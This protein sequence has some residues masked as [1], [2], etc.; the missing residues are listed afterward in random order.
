MP[1][2]GLLSFEMFAGDGIRSLGCCVD[3]KLRM[4]LTSL[5]CVEQ[6][7]YI[8]EITRSDMLHDDMYYKYTYHKKG[9]K[10]A[11]VLH[12]KDQVSTKFIP[13]LKSIPTAGS[14]SSIPLST[15]RSSVGRSTAQNTGRL[16][17]LERPAN[18]S[19]NGAGSAMNTGRRASNT[20]SWTPSVT[21]TVNANSGAKGMESKSD[22]YEDESQVIIAGQN[23]VVVISG[24]EDDLD[25]DD[26]FVL[27]GQKVVE[28]FN[29]LPSYQERLLHQADILGSLWEKVHPDDVNASKVE[30]SSGT[31]H[32][33]QSLASEYRIFNYEDAN[34]HLH[35]EADVQ[36]SYST[37]FKM[38][39]WI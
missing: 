22:E 6:R 35:D 13:P 38:E 12:P 33:T 19:G 3:I 36:W 2:K 16:S 11:I 31:D 27:S 29:Q 30:F 24:V 23:T 20:V 1:K 10:E 37:N 15:T 9:Q 4:I 8:G 25:G 32:L 26:S 18:D 21:R 5:V 17:V 14:T 7:D 28:H 39:S 34:C